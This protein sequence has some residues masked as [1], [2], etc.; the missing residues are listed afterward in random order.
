MQIGL[1]V[2]EVVPPQ[3][4]SVVSSL[5]SID[6]EAA[7]HALVDIFLWSFHIRMQCVCDCGVSMAACPFLLFECS[8][9]CTQMQSLLMVE[10]GGKPKTL[11]SDV[12]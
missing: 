5:T 2:P 12:W 1:G 10:G 3:L 8:P 7:L 6:M 11:S 9:A 4:L